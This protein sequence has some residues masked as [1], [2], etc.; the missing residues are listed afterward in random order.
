MFI[1]PLLVANCHIRIDRPN[2]LTMPSKAPLNLN[3]SPKVLLV[4]LIKVLPSKNLPSPILLQHPNHS[5]SQVLGLLPPVPTIH[6]LSR[7]LKRRIRVE[8]VL[9]KRRLLQLQVNQVIVQQHLS[10]WVLL[11]ERY[12]SYPLRHRRQ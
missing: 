7:K 5:L 8:Q 2:T 9:I 10:R 1:Q 11:L 12:L 4:P 3:I 6:R